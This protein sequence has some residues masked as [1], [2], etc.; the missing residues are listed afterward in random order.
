MYHIYRAGAVVAKR[1]QLQA[2]MV[3]AQEEAYRGAPCT[4]ISVVNRR[5]G[6]VR[7]HY[8]VDATGLNYWEG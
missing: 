6:R 2:A 1:R 5:T 7:I 8:W 3:V 4:G